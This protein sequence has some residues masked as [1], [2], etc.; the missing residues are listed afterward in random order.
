M[1]KIQLTVELTFQPRIERIELQYRMHMWQC[2]R[3]EILQI[4][5]FYKFHSLLGSVGELS[6]DK[7]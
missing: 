3:C 7:L 6:V 4:Y 5:K 2:L 1:G